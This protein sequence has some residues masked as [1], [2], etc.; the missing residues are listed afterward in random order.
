MRAYDDPKGNLQTATAVGDERIDVRSRVFVVAY[1]RVVIGTGDQEITRA[2]TI[3]AFEQFESKSGTPTAFR[4]LM[5][6]HGCS[7]QE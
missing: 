5:D 4:V 1:D 7:F 6:G 3:A 2:R